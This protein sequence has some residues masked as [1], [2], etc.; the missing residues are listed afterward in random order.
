MP[1]RNAKSAASTGTIRNARI[2]TIAL[3]LLVTGCQDRHPSAP[4][5]SSSSSSSPVTPS[6]S[7]PS[8][9][10]TVFPRGANRHT[11]RWIGQ[12]NGP[13]GTYLSLTRTGDKFLIRIKSLDGMATYEGVPV[14][15]HIEFMREGKTES[16]RAGSGKDTGMKWLLEETDCLIIR[17]GEGFC[18]KATTPIPRST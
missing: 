2:I 1:N 8:V 17:F 9:S 11:D 18:R 14:E 4:P 6:A 5:P 13:E 15:D 16:I 12:W 3:L 10:P 7:R